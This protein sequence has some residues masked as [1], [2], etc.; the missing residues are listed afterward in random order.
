MISPHRLTAGLFGRRFRCLLP[1]RAYAPAS[2]NRTHGPPVSAACYERE[3][4]DRTVPRQLRA[5][6]PGLRNDGGAAS[7]FP[8]CKNERTRRGGLPGGRFLCGTSNYH[9]PVNDLPPNVK[10]LSRSAGLSKTKPAAGFSRTGHAH[11]GTGPFPSAVRGMVLL[12]SEVPLLI[13]RP[14]IG[15]R[16]P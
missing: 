13:Y 14:H 2:A 5:D 9:Q 7:A 15:G 1:G 3:A 4:V 16:V 12:I 10:S 8:S 11:E 6:I